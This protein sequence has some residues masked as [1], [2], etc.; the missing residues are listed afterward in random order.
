MKSI[1]E[2]RTE[3]LNRLI[4]Q[5]GSV[6][7]FAEKIERSTTQVSQWKKNHPDSR[8]GKPRVPNSG[9]CRMIETKFNLPT[10]WMDIDQNQEVEDQP[11]LKQKSSSQQ[12]RFTDIPF[13][14]IDGAET[15][16]SFPLPQQILDSLDLKKTNAAQIIQAYSSSM[17]PTIKNGS[18]VIIDTTDI[19]PQDGKVYLIQDGERLLLKRLIFEYNYLLE[20]SIWVMKS[21][22]QDKQTFPD[23]FLP[24]IGTGDIIGRA[25][26]HDNKL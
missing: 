12:P 7:N 5:C 26:W 16:N 22:N 6:K 23:K 9:S 15:P 1:E 19:K 21:D 3:N 13:L 4:E 20:K 8:T 17:H 14:K 2:I 24:P 10:G 25:V 11:V 18:R